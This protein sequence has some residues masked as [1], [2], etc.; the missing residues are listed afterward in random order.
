[1]RARPRRAML[2][3]VRS[4]SVARRL[5]AMSQDTAILLALLL[6]GAGPLLATVVGM[7]AEGQIVLICASS[8][9]MAR[10]IR[11]VTPLAFVAAALIG[12]ALA[13]FIGP[14]QDTAELIV[15][16]IVFACVAPAAVLD[17]HAWRRGS[18]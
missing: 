5:S 3:F 13:P 4:T 2:D 7:P 12:F 17:V 9:F 16:A 1:L 6:A 11:L 10:A 8:I 18:L 14:S 15:V